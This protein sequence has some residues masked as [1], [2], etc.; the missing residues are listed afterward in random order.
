[1]SA[2]ESDPASPRQLLPRFLGRDPLFYAGFLAIIGVSL[3]HHTDF[4]PWVWIF[5]GLAAAMLA[6]FWKRG[7]GIVF[8]AVLAGFAGLHEIREH[9]ED[10]ISPLWEGRD[11]RLASTRVTISGTVV[12]RPRPPRGDSEIWRLTVKLDA[13]EFVQNEE[14]RRIETTN[15]IHVFAPGF[16]ARRGDRITAE[17]VLRPMP[18]TRNPGEFSR[19]KYARDSEGVVAELK[20][21]SRFRLEVTGV[22]AWQRMFDLALR[23]RNWVGEKITAGLDPRSREAQI[24]KA[25]TLGARDEA[26]PEV[27]EPFR[28]SGALHVFAVSGLHVGIFG[29]V[30]WVL[31]RAFRVPR[32]GAIFVIIVCVLGY[33]FITGLRPSAVRAAIMT[34]I[35]LGGFCLRRKS[36]LLNSLGC[37]ALVILLVD[38]RQL[39]AVGFQLSFAVLT[40]ISLLTPPLRRLSARWLDPD[41]FVPSSLVGQGKRLAIAGGKRLFDVFW[42]SLAASVGSAGFILWYFG[43]LTP[44]A[45]I[46][47]CVLVPLAWIVICFATVSLLVGRIPLVG[48][49]IGG[50]L[51]WVNSYL[52]TWIFGAVTFF[53]ETPNGHFEVTPLS[54]R[55]KA[56]SGEPGIVVFDLERSCG[57]QAIHFRDEASGQTRTW[58]IDSGHSSNY[59]RVVRPWLRKNG[60]ERL[61]GLVA[62]HGDADHI[63]AARQLLK[64]FRPAQIVQSQ[65][66]STSQSFKA[67][68]EF[69]R[70]RDVSVLQPAAGARIELGA[71]AA[72]E[73]LFPP[74]GFPDQGPGDDECLVVMTHWRGFRILNTSDS[75][76]RTETWLLENVEPAALRADVLVKSQHSADHSGLP[77]FLRAVAPKAVIATNHHFPENEKISEAWRQLL[78]DRLG[79]ALFDQAESGA[80]TMR[81]RDGRLELRG[82]VDGRS[83]EIE[84]SAASGR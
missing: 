54:E 25:M 41:P 43:L 9:E 40:S 24:L 51:N 74:A 58:L 10:K 49:M 37:A 4:S 21:P 13:I 1:M 11:Q 5:A 33:A 23:T 75:G 68:A 29:T 50:W 7:R 66:P 84:P 19:S 14:R 65:L 64:D 82:F 44:I 2:T 76:F 22:S 69:R 8:G 39:F 56:E 38:T 80:V 52:V 27:E 35:F 47:N 77:K 70:A 60:I 31:L 36:R 67:L 17:G 46:A 78:E 28:L 6:F 62:S 18:P 42:V 45:V 55:F 32:R 20:V 72:L 30:I 57:P 26:D 12:A 16:L 71:D 81:I 73:I 79:I 3:A 61:D 15:R 83:V 34:S 63:G 53:A 59:R 48:G